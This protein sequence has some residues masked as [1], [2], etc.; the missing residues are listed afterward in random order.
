MAAHL[1]DMWPPS[2]LLSGGIIAL[3][4]AAPFPAPHGGAPAT[5]LTRDRGQA[6]QTW[7]PQRTGRGRPA[8]PGGQ[9][10][11]A[12]NAARAAGRGGLPRLALLF[13]GIT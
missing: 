6:A 7:S 3:R 13:P 12:A 4:V 9:R 10:R 5:F 1:I 8:T 2:S 11:I